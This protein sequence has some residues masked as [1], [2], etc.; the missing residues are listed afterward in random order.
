MEVE[1][2]DEEGSGVEE[3]HGEDGDK[4]EYMKKVGRGLR[5]F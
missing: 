4:D 2:R 3:R 1:G 5:R